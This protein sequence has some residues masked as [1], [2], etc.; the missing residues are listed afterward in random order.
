MD[1]KVLNDSELTQL[2]QLIVDCKRVVVICHKSPDGDAIGSS[3][4]WAEYLR[5]QGKEVSVVVPDAYP[6]FLQWLPNTQLIM[7]YDKKAEE[8]KTVFEQA[9]LVCCMDFNESSRVEELQPLLDAF[10]GKRL[11]IDHHLNPNLDDA[12]VISRSQLC[13]TCELVFS[14]LW[15][16]DAYE[17]MTHAMAVCLYCGMMTDTGGFTY[18]STRPEIFYIIS[19]LLDKRVNKDLVYNRVYHNYSADAIRLR[20]YVISRK[21]RVSNELHAAYFTLTRDEMK[22]YHFIKGDAEGLVNEP[23]RI[24]G[25]KVSISLREDTEKPNLILVSLRSSCGFHCAEMARRFFNGG[26]HE[27]AAGGKLFCSITEAEQIT[28]QAI[29]AFR[30]QLQ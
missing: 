24:K 19:L 2:R 13:S 4:A 18:N 5:Q 21:M 9:D 11:M 8:V 22:R 16:L 3:L 28:T 25:M 29:L 27:D 23:L 15:Q 17:P 6:D 7:R 10:Q 12:M 26:G 1:I 14:I 30:E 20:G